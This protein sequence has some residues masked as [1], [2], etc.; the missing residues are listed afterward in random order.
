MYENQIKGKY[1][2]ANGSI[3]KK[4]LISTNTMIISPIIPYFLSMKK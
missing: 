3:F 4:K 1:K 2:L